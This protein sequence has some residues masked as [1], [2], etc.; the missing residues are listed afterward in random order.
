MN[1]ITEKPNYKKFDVVRKSEDIP[2]YVKNKIKYHFKTPSEKYV[3]PL[4]SSQEFGWDRSEY[5][6]WK[7]KKHPRQTCDVT[8]YAD[9]YQSLTGQ[10]PY[11]NKITKK[12]E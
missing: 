6:N 1:V 2:E 9:E 10:S 3:T 7:T 11:A 12:K 8:R 5:L 4:T